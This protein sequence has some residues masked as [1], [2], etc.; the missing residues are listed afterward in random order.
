MLSHTNVCAHRR[1]S[2]DDKKVRWGGMGMG[3][4]DTSNDFCRPSLCSRRSLVSR[5]DL[6]PQFGLVALELQGPRLHVRIYVCVCEC[7]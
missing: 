3:E 1:S 5:G 2:S 7:V 6:K 4:D